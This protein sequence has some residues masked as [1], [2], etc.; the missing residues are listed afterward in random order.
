MINS[1]FKFSIA[2][3]MCECLRLLGNRMLVCLFNSFVEVGS[4][5]RISWTLISWPGIVDDRIPDEQGNRNRLR[6]ISSPFLPPLGIIFIKKTSRASLLSWKKKKKNGEI[7]HVGKKEEKKRSYQP[8]LGLLRNYVLGRDA[9]ENTFLGAF[10]SSCPRN[11][12]TE[13]IPFFNVPI[14]PYR[15]ETPMFAIASSNLDDFQ[16]ERKSGRNF[17]EDNRRVIIFR[18]KEKFQVID[19][20]LA[21][22]ERGTRFSSLRFSFLFFIFSKMLFASHSNFRAN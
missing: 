19:V 18:E 2:V 9:I 4:R 11:N 15:K 12:T 14:S 8:F 7:C 16:V 3:W 21:W 6:L 17:E 20:E 5:T 13:T 22:N 10:I 1:C